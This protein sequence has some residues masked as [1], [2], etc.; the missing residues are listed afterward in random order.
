MLSPAIAMLTGSGLCQSLAG[1]IA[2]PP[3][4]ISVVPGGIGCCGM[5]VV[6]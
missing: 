3:R 5:S 4:T 1:S 2:R 6:N